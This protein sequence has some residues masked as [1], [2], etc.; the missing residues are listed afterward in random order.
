MVKLVRQSGK[1]PQQGLCSVIY[2]QRVLETCCL[3]RWHLSHYRGCDCRRL[4]MPHWFTTPGSSGELGSQLRLESLGW[5][6]E[7]PLAGRQFL[8]LWNESE[9]AEGQKAPF[10]CLTVRNPQFV[11]HPFKGF[12]ASNPAWCWYIAKQTKPKTR[13]L[14]FADTNTHVF[15]AWLSFSLPPLSPP[16]PHPLPL[17]SLC[18]CSGHSIPSPVLEPG[19]IT[20]L[21]VSR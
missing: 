9:R 14:P 12:G 3:R 19:P 8:P 13:T 18:L 17:A 6:L 15:S 5:S 2:L 10:P 1:H 16:L 11:K 4:F 21:S 20:K 7:S